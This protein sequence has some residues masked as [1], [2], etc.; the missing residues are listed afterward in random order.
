M[1]NYQVNHSQAADLYQ[2]MP[3]K[4]HQHQMARRHFQQRLLGQ[5]WSK[6]HWSGNQKKGMGVDQLHTQEVPLKHHKASP[7]L[8]ST[9]KAKS[10]KTE[11]DLAQ[12]YWCRGEGHR[13]DMS[14]A[15]EDLTELVPQ[16]IKRLKQASNTSDST[17]FALHSTSWL[18]A[19]V[20]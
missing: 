19:Q 15:E 8:E 12:Q 17:T 1:E 9:G 10:K 4:H 13:N 6:P 3:Q 14:T 18:Q 11:T 16:G 5:N 2:Q 7:W 20:Y